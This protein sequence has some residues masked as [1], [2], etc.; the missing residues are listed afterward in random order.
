MAIFMDPPKFPWFFEEA[1]ALAQGL[2][3]GLILRVNDLPDQIRVRIVFLRG[4]T[5]NAGHRGA[6]V[7][8]AR[9]GF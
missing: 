9:G 6:Y 8:E 5:G 1:F 7:L 2:Q 4:V 3:G